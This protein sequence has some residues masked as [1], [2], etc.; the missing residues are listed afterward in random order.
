MPQNILDSLQTYNQLIREASGKQAELIKEIAP[1]LK[2]LNLLYKSMMPGTPEGLDTKTY[3]NNKDRLFELKTEI[4]E[5]TSYF[6][7]YVNVTNS[8][9][10]A[11]SHI[12]GSYA[13]KTLF[14]AATSLLQKQKG[15]KTFYY[16]TKKTFDKN[17]QLEI[18]MLAE[19]DDEIFIVEVKSILKPEV[20]GQL[21]NIVDKFNTHFPQ[22]EGIKTV[23][24]LACLS[25]TNNLIEVAK[26]SGV[27]VITQVDD[28][29][30]F[31]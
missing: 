25:A 1:I 27:L 24:V 9:H 15:C 16:K 21:I 22:D 23:P 11:Y 30:M 26:N 4:K 28:V 29:F 6:K 2:D 31:V 3:I 20:F 18:D 5:I 10:G 19:G 13:E 8:I 17:K 12:W 14:D 7:D